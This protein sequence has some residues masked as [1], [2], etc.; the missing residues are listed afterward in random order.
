MSN[1]F[2]HIYRIPVVLAL[3]AAF[4]L[5]A[6]LLTDGPMDLLWTAAVAIPLLVILWKLRASRAAPTTPSNRT[7]P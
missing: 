3:I 7:E 6:A 5:I 1:V 2:G 4:G